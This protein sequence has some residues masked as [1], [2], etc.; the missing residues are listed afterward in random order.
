MVGA[1]LVGLLWAVTGGGEDR[2]EGDT[3]TATG[4]VHVDD[5]YAERDEDADSLVACQ[6][7]FQ[8]DGHKG[9]A[10]VTVLNGSGE[11]LAASALGPNT[12]ADEEIGS[13]CLLRFQVPDVPA[14]EKHYRIAVAGQSPVTTTED[15]LSS[16][17]FV[18]TV[19]D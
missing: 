6:S 8:K 4:V 15:V 16:G 11:V 5:E 14:G 1:A 2:S 3:F 19:G 9:G 17:S 10:E 18:S 12:F 13:D 7:D